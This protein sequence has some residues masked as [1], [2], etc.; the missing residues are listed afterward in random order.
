MGDSGGDGGAETEGHGYDQEGGGPERGRDAGL[1]SLLIIFLGYRTYTE[2]NKEA[3]PVYFPLI[4]KFRIN[5]MHFFLQEFR[6]IVER[7][8]YI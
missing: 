4:V 3:V 8:I 7:I 2:S 1:W 5:K 6:K